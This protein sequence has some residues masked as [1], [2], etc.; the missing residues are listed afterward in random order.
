[1][2][3]DRELAKEEIQR[4]LKE[5]S[6]GKLLYKALDAFME[7][8]TKPTLHDLCINELYAIAEGEKELIIEQGREINN[9]KERLKTLEEKAKP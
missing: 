3:P 2:T 6:E 1:M 7:E 8:R 9:L 5:A 4:F